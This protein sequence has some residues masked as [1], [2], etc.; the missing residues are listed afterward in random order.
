MNVGTLLKSL[1]YGEL[2]NLSM[3]N[4]DTGVILEAKQP[5]LIDHANTA[6]LDLFTRFILLEKDVIIERKEH[7][8]FYPLSSRYAVTNPDPDPAD[9][10]FLVDS[11][12]KPFTDDVIKILSVFNIEGEL[13]P[14]NDIEHSMSLFTPQPTVLQVPVLLEEQPLG[15]VYQAHHPLL[16][17]ETIDETETIDL[18]VSLHN[19]LKAHIA[20]QVYSGMN[21]QEHS[22]KANEHFTRYE[23][24]C[25]EVRSA[26]LV[27]SSMSFTS[28]KFHDRGFV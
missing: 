1:A 15:V 5:K 10:L 7:L 17:V 28:Y 3:S 27:N 24:I 6:L 18:P 4:S 8:L 21:G 20:Y 26:D 12:F 25:E 22:A 13:M 14:L 11:E 9:T 19:A 23:M 2:S 16:T